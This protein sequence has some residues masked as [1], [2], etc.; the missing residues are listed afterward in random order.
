[1]WKGTGY[2]LMRLPTYLNATFRHYKTMQKSTSVRLSIIP[3]LLTLFGSVA[4]QMPTR[5]VQ[6]SPPVGVQEDMTWWYI[7]LFVLLVA[8]AGAIGWWYKTKYGGEEKKE[9]RV[10]YSGDDAN[11]DSVDADSELAWLKKVSKKKAS[12]NDYKFPEGLPRTS[13]VLSKNG[14]NSIDAEDDASFSETKRR[15]KQ[16]QFERLPINSF[17]GLKNPKPFD[18]L[19]ISNDDALMSAIEQAQCEDEEDPEI[20]ELAIRI[21]ARFKNRNSIESLSQ[22]AMYDVSSSLR[23]KAVLAL[24]DFDHESVFESILLCCADPTREVRAAAARALFNLN[25]DRAE[26][27]SRIALC[28]DE[29]GMVQAA[30][31]AIE[32]DLVE[33]SIERLVH[34]DVNHSYEAFALV[35]LL[36]K[37]GET[38]EI[39]SLLESHADN[40]V[41]LALIR[42]F[43]IIEDERATE[44]LFSYM[45]RNTLSEEIGRAV[46]ECIKAPR[47]VPV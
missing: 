28:N 27:W 13:R 35:A 46:N 3:A 14:I 21:L 34:E 24:A 5:P 33:R 43:S 44:K 8:L 23:S 45:E 37:A 20:R 19:P 16:D 11:A 12:K 42:V 32:S 38:M 25:F 7:S 9:K 36:I 1:M 39:F 31:A 26:C 30:R 18:A 47:L 2:A 4:A 15:I 40:F 6:P 29:F 17:D 41:K 10:D 22:M